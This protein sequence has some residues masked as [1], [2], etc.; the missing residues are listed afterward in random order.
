MAHVAL[1]RITSNFQITMP[2]AAREALRLKRGDFLEATV[3]RGAVVLKPKVIRDRSEFLKQLKKDI[4]AS[5]VAVK[6]GRVLGPFD[7]ADAA[8]KAVKAYARRAHRAIRP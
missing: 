2:K 7:S 6:A 1:T 5:K 8:M 3:Q 4:E